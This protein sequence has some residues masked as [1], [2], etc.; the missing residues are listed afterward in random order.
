LS[1]I[2]K[3]AT[4][5]HAYAE[6]NGFLTLLSDGERLTGAYA[7]GPEAGEWLQ[8][9]TLA[10]RARVPLEVL[11]DTIQPFPSFSEIHAAALKALR[12]E[13]AAARAAVGA[14]SG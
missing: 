12:R 13:I 2:A 7:L 5:T 1:E 14:G 11:R 3:T 6:S 10:I 9:A 4:Y 8:Q